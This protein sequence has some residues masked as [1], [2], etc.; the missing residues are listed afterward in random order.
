MKLV[1]TVIIFLTVGCQ[2][3]DSRLSTGN[4]VTT[5]KNDGEALFKANCAS[6]HKPNEDFAG[7]ALRGSFER[8]NNK[9]LL[10]EFIRN[11]QP[12]IEKDEYAKRLQQKYKTSMTAFPALTNE[13]IDAI[14]NFCYHADPAPVIN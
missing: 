11:P 12:I 8:W 6:C 4:I 5:S 13:D 9:A 10:Y 3:N 14:L 7:P 2:T 1:F